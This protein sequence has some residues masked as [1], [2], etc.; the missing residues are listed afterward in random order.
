MS[1]SVALSDMEAEPV[2]NA[3]EGRSKRKGSPLTK[4][5][6]KKQLSTDRLSTLRRQNSAPDI[7]KLLSAK[8]R[9]GSGMAFSDMV[10]MT[11]TDPSF[12]TSI[13]PVLYD[14]ISPLILSTIETSVSK[15]VEAAVKSV[16]TN[17]IDEMLES[18]KKLQ[19]SVSKQSRII[20]EQTKV[21]EKQEKFLQDQNKTIKDQTILL[22][23][24]AEKIDQLEMQ[25][26]SLMVELDGL[27]YEL[28]DLGQYGR[29]NSIRLNN[30]KIVM[31]LKSEEELTE[32]VVN[33]LNERVLQL[34]DP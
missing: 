31:P 7:P 22:H 4:E 33:F 32:C 17:V 18:N 16:Q 27:R 5:E 19:E 1:K 11:F 24:K 15:T 13:T 29:R 3:E 2:E 9:K 30:F 10:K 14:M 28:N 26:D 21:I 23:E 34:G 12:A 6:V 8:E 25:V 20:Q